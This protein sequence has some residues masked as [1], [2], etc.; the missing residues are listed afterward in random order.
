MINDNVGLL[1]GHHLD[2]LHFANDLNCAIAAV[3][4]LVLDHIADLFLLVEEQSLIYEVLNVHHSAHHFTN[5]G[6]LG[7][8]SFLRRGLGGSLLGFLGG[9]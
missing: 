1:A 2:V 3:E 9:F 6:L 5:G 7:R 8:C 4:D